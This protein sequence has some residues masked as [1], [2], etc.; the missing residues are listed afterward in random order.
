MV[1]GNGKM[2]SSNL[3]GGATPTQEFPMAKAPIFNS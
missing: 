1:G 3:I 2:I